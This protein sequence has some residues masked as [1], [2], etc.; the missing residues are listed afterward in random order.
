MR[1]LRPAAAL[2]HPDELAVDQVLLLDEERRIQAWMAPEDCPATAII[3]EFPDEIWAAAP[4]LLHAHLESYDAPSADWP[5]SNFAEWAAALLQWRIEGQGCLSAENA[6]A[7]SLRELHAR[8]CGFVLASTS[9]QGA[10]QVHAPDGLVLESWPEL[11]EPDPAQAEACMARFLADFPKVR[12]VALHA[13]FSV[14]PEL[15]RLAC[16]WASA[17]GRYLS[18]HL[19]EHEDERTLLAEHSGPLAELMRLR[20]R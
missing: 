9:E 5:R 13:P 10:A 16:D 3:E 12:G 20:G 7:A 1:Y 6:A 17:P 18:I 8:G 19:G 2:L 11:F 15:A 4:R 14:S